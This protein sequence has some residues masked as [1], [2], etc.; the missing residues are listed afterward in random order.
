MSRIALI[1]TPWPLFNCPSIQLGTLKAFARQSLPKVRVDTHHV[2]LS[3]ANVLGYDLYSQISERT[4]LSE[5]PYAALLYQERKEI[6]TRFWRRQSSRLPLCQKTNFKEILDKLETVSDQILRSLNWQDYD[7]VGL[8]I[9]FGQLTSSLFFIHQI[10]QRSPSLKI[11]VGGSA[12]AG[13]LGRSLLHVFSEIDFVIS[14]EGELPLVHLI[15]WLSSSGGKGKPDPIPGLLGRNHGSGCETEE[16]SQLPQ[17]DQLP[18]PDYSDYF[19][20]LKSLQPHRVFIPKLPMEI[21]R[22]CWWGKNIAGRTS[23]GCA[24]CN[25]NL[26]WQGYRAKPQEKVI[27]ELDALTK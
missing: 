20:H 15:R 3:V 1:S 9:C 12:C 17:L 10:K 6:I 18:M 16:F 2:Y 14:G 5:L 4:W 23:R 11:V 13:E 7:L 19:T 8:S 21:S 25:L 27:A 22:G 26:Q 24:F